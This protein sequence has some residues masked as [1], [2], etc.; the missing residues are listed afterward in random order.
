MSRSLSAS[1]ALTL[2]HSRH[3]S[4]KRLIASPFIFNRALCLWCFPL[5]R[6]RRS[7]QAQTIR[8][9]L[10]GVTIRSFLSLRGFED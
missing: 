5:S 2:I 6:R 1:I 8:H 4:P 10:I 3:L 7:S 9:L